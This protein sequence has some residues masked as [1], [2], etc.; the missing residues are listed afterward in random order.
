[1]DPPERP[2]TLV[3]GVLDP[4][5][6]D[7]T[8]NFQEPLPASAVKVGD[9]VEFSGVGE[10]FTKEPYMLTFKDAELP[11]VKAVKAP[12]KRGPRRQVKTK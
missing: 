6:P 8:L 11:G 12:T 10:S 5:K 3:L 2:K 7:A 9:K 4:T 1:M